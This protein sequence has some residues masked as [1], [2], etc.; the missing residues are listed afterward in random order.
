TDLQVPS[1]YADI[2]WWSGGPAPGEQGAAVVVGHVDSP[3]GPAVFYQLSGLARGDRIVVERA[4]LARMV[5]AVQRVT[6]YERSEFPSERVYRTRGPSTLSL[7]TC[8]GSFDAEAGQYTGNVVVF[9]RLVD[10]VPAAQAEPDE[11]EQQE[12]QQQE[13][14]QQETQ[15]QETQQQETLP[16]RE[17]PR[18]YRAAVRDARERQESQPQE[19][20]QETQRPEAEPLA[21]QP[22]WYRAAV[23]DARE[24]LATQDG[25][26]DG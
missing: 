9:A 22:Q 14:Q 26:D 17:Q 10:R 7:L 25:G 23:Q 11:T 5:Y 2:G 20:Q 19:S 1:D 15:Q 4:D 12:T 6:L 3:T 13:T 24:R 21:E 16:L 18:W 8:G